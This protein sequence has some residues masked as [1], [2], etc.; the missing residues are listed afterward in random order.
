VIPD[1]RERPT[2]SVE[3][4]G[5]LLGL[6]RSAAYSA[7]ARY[8]ATKGTEGLPVIAF[9]RRLVVPTAKLLALLGLHDDEG[10]VARPAPPR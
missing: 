10:G 1:A 7:A 2:L 8:L 4:G 9:G 6:G 3:E 5:R